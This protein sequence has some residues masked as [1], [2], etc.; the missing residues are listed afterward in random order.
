MLPVKAAPRLS[1]SDSYDLK[2]TL[3]K[4]AANQTMENLFPAMLD[5]V[6]FRGLKSWL[7]GKKQ[8]RKQN[9]GGKP[10]LFFSPFPQDI[11]PLSHNESADT[12][13][14]CFEAIDFTAIKKVLSRLSEKDG[15]W[16]D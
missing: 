7:C 14:E 11:I 1:E 4:E 8:V 12:V 16:S 5:S 10:Q 9:E 6:Y 3:L 13:T 15:F 2:N